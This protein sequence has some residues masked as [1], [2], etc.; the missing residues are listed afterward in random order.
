MCSDQLDAKF[1]ATRRASA[2]LQDQIVKLK[3]QS[4]AADRAVEEF[5]RKNNMISADGRLVNEQQVGE[6]SSQLASARRKTADTQARLER[7]QTILS[8]DTV[9]ATV[10][11]SLNNMVVTKLREKYLDDANKEADWSARF[12]PNHLAAIN[13]RNQMKG[14]LCLNP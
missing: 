6:L 2:W 1:Q 7:I 4:A 14:I 5:K 8:G 13:L 11:D 10:T 9:N 3:E 12:G